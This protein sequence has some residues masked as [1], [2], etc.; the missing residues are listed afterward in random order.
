MSVMVANH[1]VMAMPWV[2][3]TSGTLTP[4]VWVPEPD[5]GIEPHCYLLAWFPVRVVSAVDVGAS[6]CAE[7]PVEALV[8]RD[9]VEA[10]V[11]EHGP[12]RLQ[13]LAYGV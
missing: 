12:G 4:G 5:A 8:A 3:M 13:R 9:L 1:R 2:P 7:I 6:T 10:H 11:G